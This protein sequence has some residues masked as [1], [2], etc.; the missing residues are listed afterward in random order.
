MFM[1]SALLLITSPAL[2]QRPALPLA[3]PARLPRSAAV[4]S[5]QPPWLSTARGQGAGSNQR[6]QELTLLG[7]IEGT[8]RGVQATDEARRTIAA[9]IGDLEDGWRGTDVFSAAQEPYLLRRTEV[10]YV[11]QASSGRANA[12]GGKYRGR[13][14][15]LLFRT[16]ALFQHVLPDAVAVNVIQFKLLGL[17]PGAAVLP[18]RWAVATA[19]ERVALQRNGS[20][21]V[22]PNTVAVDFDA[23]RV[24]FGR[25]G[26][27]LTL[28]VGPTSRVGLDTTYLSERLRICRGAGSG[29]PFV[30]RADTART[31]APLARASQQWRDCV[32]RRPLGKRG[33]VT[34]AAAAAA[35]ASSGLLPIPR[36]SAVPLAVAATGLLRSTGGIVTDERRREV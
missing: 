23:P 30:F 36:W 27:L 22:S 32:A 9:L 20:R 29:V 17:V 11:G 8:D 15:R 16:T 14:G 35:A 13:V 28:Q 21:A 26:R 10:A 5:E 4:L 24:C 31:A 34:V 1:A 7:L 12:A 33:A 18:G 2:L 3:R 19:D 6:D 25:S